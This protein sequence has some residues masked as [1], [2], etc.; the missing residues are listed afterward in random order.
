M[1]K[2]SRSLEDAQQMGGEQATLRQAGTKW[3]THALMVYDAEL[4]KKALA[5]SQAIAEFCNELE[6]G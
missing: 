5:I 1:E 6:R 4:L 2:L 3:A